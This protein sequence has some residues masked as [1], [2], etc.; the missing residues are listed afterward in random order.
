MAEWFTEEKERK[1]VERNKR[2]NVRMCVND[3]NQTTQ[4]GTQKKKTN[5]LRRIS[6]TCK[7]DK[8][9]LSSNYVRMVSDVCIYELSVRDRLLINRK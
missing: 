3:T 2:M 5:S 9:L 4:T 6:I 1:N 8:K 7:K